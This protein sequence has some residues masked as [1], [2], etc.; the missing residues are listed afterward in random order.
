M[1]EWFP[2]YVEFWGYMVDYMR[3]RYHKK[4]STSAGPRRNSFSSQV[5][6]YIEYPIKNFKQLLNAYR[7]YFWGSFYTPRWYNLSQIKVG[8]VGGFNL[9]KSERKVQLDD[10]GSK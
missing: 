2:T 6:S 3:A 5:I 9:I 4:F 7:I 10:H 1:K 8:F